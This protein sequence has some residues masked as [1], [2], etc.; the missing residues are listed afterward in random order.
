M[1][2]LSVFQ[3]ADAVAII[4]DGFP[5]VTALLLL[6]LAGAMAASAVVF[7]QRRDLAA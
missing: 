6:A 7:F 2:E 1:A 5:T 4:R 3:H